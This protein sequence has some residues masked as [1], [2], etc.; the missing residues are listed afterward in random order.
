MTVTMMT[1]A[2]G[3]P[4]L[5]AQTY[6]AGEAA[7]LLAGH[8]ITKDAARLES[9]ELAST[10]ER[11]F[12]KLAAASRKRRTADPAASVSFTIGIGAGNSVNLTLQA[13]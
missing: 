3:R 12:A 4:V 5:I 2:A 1:I 7:E 9:R 10:L 11:A 6:T 13:D 8:P